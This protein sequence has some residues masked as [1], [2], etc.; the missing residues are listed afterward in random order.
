MA[1][2]EGEKAPDFKRFDQNDKE[3]SL[4]DYAGKYLVDLFLPK[5]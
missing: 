3:H 1:I 4:A 2:V 5:R